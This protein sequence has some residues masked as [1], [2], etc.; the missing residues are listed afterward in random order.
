MLRRGRFET[1]LGP[2]AFDGKGDLE[3]ASWQWQRWSDGS[4]R[5]LSEAAPTRAAADPAA[6]PTL[7]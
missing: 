4:Y 7:R 2:I 3:G 1:V 6:M 5:P